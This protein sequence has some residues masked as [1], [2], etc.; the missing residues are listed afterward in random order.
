MFTF[1]LPTDCQNPKYEYRFGA[2]GTELTL[3]NGV[4]NA[5]VKCSEYLDA[6]K[7]EVIVIAETADGSI[8]SVDKQIEIASEHRG[9]TATCTEQA[10]CEICGEKYG[11][12]DSANHTDASNGKQ[13]K[14]S[15]RRFGA[16]A[17]LL[18]LPMK[19]TSG[20]MELAR[21][22]AIPAN[23]AAA[24]QPARIWRF[25]NSAVSSTASL[26]PITM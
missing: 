18:M 9:G 11:N 16:A 7:L 8:F 21:S 3:E 2:F 10:V 4:Y 15:T 23:T 17:L 22:A 25:A 6:D 1:V 5:S 13:P 19:V 24:R 12:V 14:P 20:A 26:M